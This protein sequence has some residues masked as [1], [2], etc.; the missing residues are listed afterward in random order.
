LTKSSGWKVILLTKDNIDQFI[1]IPNYVLDKIGNSITYTHLSDIIRITLLA[2]Y[3][4]F[5]VDATIFLTKQ[6]P[7]EIKNKDF[8]TVRNFPRKMLCVSLSRWSGNFMFAAEGN[9]LIKKMYM[10]IME[11]W[12]KNDFLIDYFLID[13]IINYLYNTD[14][15]CRLLL[16]AVPISNPEMYGGLINILKNNE[17]NNKNKLN[18][19]FS[20][21]WVHKL[22]WKEKVPIER[23]QALVDIL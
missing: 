18:D 8:F 3:G 5:W 2:T 9:L 6:I 7:S 11:Y 1:S 21:T 16:D 10:L 14:D 12:K 4:G 22:S 13:Y 19:I 20:S 23:L 15:E 17:V